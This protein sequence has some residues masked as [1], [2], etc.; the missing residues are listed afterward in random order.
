MPLTQISRLDASHIA[1]DTVAGEARS[2]LTEPAL[3]ADA[4]A[5]AGAYAFEMGEDGYL[6]FADVPSVERFIVE[7]PGELSTAQSDWEN[8]LSAE[9][10]RA[11][12]RAISSLRFIGARY[13]IDYAL[14]D[15]MGEIRYVREIAEAQACA[16]NRA[17]LIRG[18][19]IDRTDDRRADEAIAWRARHD[20]LTRL[21][22]R[23]ALQADATQMAALGARVGVPVHLIRLRLSNLDAL[24]LNF[25]EDMRDHLLRAAAT[26]IHGAKRAPDLVARLGGA[27]FAVCSP[28]SDPETLAQ[29]LRATVAAQ[30]Y[31][32]PFGPLALEVTC[33]AVPLTTVD[34]ALMA[35]REDFSNNDDVPERAAATAVDVQALLDND[36]L[37]LAF[38]P[39][40]HAGSG[41]LH[42]HECLLR[43]RTDDGRIESAFRVILA[44]E[45]DGMVDQ[46]DTR[47]LDLAIPHLEADDSVHLALNVSAGTIADDE[48]SARYIDRLRD[49]G[50]AAAR[51]TIEMTETLA[52]DDPAKASRFAAEVRGLGC[53]FA[54]DDFGSGHT[55][56]R[57][58]LAVE[59]DSIKID[60]SLVLGVAVDENKQAFIRMMVD[61]AAT[62]SVDTVA[63]MVEDK[64]DAQI[65]ARLGVNYLQGYYFGRP[66]PSPV[67]SRMTG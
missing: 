7:R 40:V 16:D 53:R 13:Q 8:R 43:V 15:A 20:P 12:R 44:A 67:W 48:A 29:F 1:A 36:R 18:V 42:H 54:V 49:L 47:A 21:P 37:S 61:L 64:A 31:A 63:E 30:P 56:F 57:N 27:D 66:A 60:G 55:S 9:D 58:L 50:D 51:L 46:L 28:N 23:S 45:K 22:N 24:T 32:T 26:R 19:M 59:A 39:I 5:L 11:R 52:V 10:I 14:R 25:G 41:D 33:S 17:T 35:T 62:F 38:Q 34:E 3:L 2:P 65:L 6:D 4:L